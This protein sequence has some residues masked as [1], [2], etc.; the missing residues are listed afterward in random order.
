[1]TTMWRRL[2]VYA[3][4]GA[5]DALGTGSQFGTSSQK[6]GRRWRP[7][8]P[9]A[10]SLSSG[11]GI[12][13]GSPGLGSTESS[14]L[15]HRWGNELQLEVLILE[16]AIE[17]RNTLRAT[18]WPIALTAAILGEFRE[19]SQPGTSSVETAKLIKCLDLLWIQNRF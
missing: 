1:M 15:S 14:I 4:N 3:G 2:G 11:L 7:S 8:P 10:G 19:K 18:E 17:S 6:R 12:I 9:E 16:D 13:S 5:V